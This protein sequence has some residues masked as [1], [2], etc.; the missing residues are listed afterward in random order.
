MQELKIA[1]VQACTIWE[2]PAGNRE[3]LAKMLSDIPEG[4]L[5]LLPEFFTAGVSIHNIRIV[6]TARDRTLKWMMEMAFQKNITIGG[7]FLVMDNGRIYN[8]AY[9]TNTQGVLGYY[10][11]RHLFSL[12][13]ENETISPGHESKTLEVNGFQIQPLICYDLRFPVWSRNRKMNDSFLYDI[14]VYHANWPDPRT[15]PWRQL[16]IARAIENQCYVIGINR[17][18]TDN[19]GMVYS[20]PTMV[21]DYKGKIIA[22]MPS[23]QEGVLRAS[24]EM[25][26]LNLF[27]RK[28]NV[29]AD[30]D[31]FQIRK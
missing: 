31:D 8:R 1:A 28:F 12:G 10:N 4:T 22:E 14:L 2:D 6:E 18:G 20:A 9:Y 15:Y 24:L 29:S 23:G 3:A 7:S 11:K 30:W 25:E 21:I 13:G 27:R 16:L 5:V 19:E 26:A 17:C